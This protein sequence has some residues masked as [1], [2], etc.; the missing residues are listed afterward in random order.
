MSLLRRLLHVTC[1]WF[2]GLAV[3]LAWVWIGEG[4]ATSTGGGGIYVAL[5]VLTTTVT[6][7]VL[8]ATLI[9]LVGYMIDGRDG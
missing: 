1:G 7:Y 2:I 3:T 9:N 5:V 4:K 6:V 8:G